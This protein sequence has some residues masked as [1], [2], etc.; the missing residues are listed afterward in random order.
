MKVH[1]MDF[2]SMGDGAILKELGQRLRR[3]RLNRNMT[4]A[5][6]AN[7]AGI[8]RRTL[9]KTENGEVTTLET[10]VAILRGLDL[11]AQ[12]DQFLP[13][14]PPSPIQLA[15]LQ[16]RTRQRATGTHKPEQPSSDWTWGE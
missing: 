3:T 13:E 14:P 16:G 8:G 4:Q 9:Q 15:Q 11:L 7:R 1:P 2:N 12:L 5:D 6:L 10:M